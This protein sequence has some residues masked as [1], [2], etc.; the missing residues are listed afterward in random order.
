MVFIFGRPYSLYGFMTKE[1]LG[2]NDWSMYIWFWL[3]CSHQ[4]RSIWSKL[5]FYKLFLIFAW[6]DVG[7]HLTRDFPATMSEGGTLMIPWSWTNNTDLTMFFWISSGGLG[8]HIGFLSLVSTSLFIL[9][10]RRSLPQLPRKL[11]QYCVS[12]WLLFL[13]VMCSRN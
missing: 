9:M 11:Q 7:L 1:G 5:R 6:F 12:T 10:R 13:A 8:S 3:N 2:H 4:H